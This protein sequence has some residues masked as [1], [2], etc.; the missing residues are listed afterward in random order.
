M[1]SADPF[2][3]ALGWML[4]VDVLCKVCEGLLLDSHV[5]SGGGIPNPSQYNMTESVWLI[6]M[7]LLFTVTDGGSKERRTTGNS[8]KFR[9]KNP[10]Y[11]YYSTLH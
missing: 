7:L 9:P 3:K 6:V 4:S 8:L 1:T 2:M 10:I 11:L 5:N